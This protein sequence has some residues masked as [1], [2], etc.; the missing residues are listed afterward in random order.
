MSF[1]EGRYELFLKINED[2]TQEA[3]SI[4]EASRD[5]DIN[6]SL[7]HFNWKPLHV[8]AYRGNTNLVQY[9]VEQGAD[10]TAING[11]GYTPEMLAKSN[12]HDQ[13]IELLTES[14]V[15]V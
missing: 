6:T 10:V 3:I 14:R 1:Y 8:A 12:N 2:L 4:L 15:C 9:L 13:I 11:S 7:N 5:I